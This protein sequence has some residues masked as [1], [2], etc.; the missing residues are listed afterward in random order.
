MAPPRVGSPTSPAVNNACVPEAPEAPVTTK[1]APLSSDLASSRSSVESWSGANTSRAGLLHSAPPASSGPM[2]GPTSNATRF[3]IERTLARQER[4]EALV[5]D[6]TPALETEARVHR[7]ISSSSLP[8]NLTDDV[9]KAL[10]QLPPD[11]VEAAVRESVQRAFPKASAEKLETLQRQTMAV[12][13]DTKYQLAQDLKTFISDKID[14]GARN[15]LATAKD[16]AQLEALLRHVEQLPLVERRETF[17]ALGLAPEVK[18]P[19]AAQLAKA[20]TERAAVMMRSAKDLR[21]TS[22]ADHTLFRIANYPGVEADFAKA[23]KIEPDSFAGHALHQTVADAASEKGLRAKA[24]FALGVA[25]AAAFGAVAAVVGAG[26]LGSAAIAAPATLLNTA[27]KVSEADKAVVDATA[28]ESA[29]VM[30]RGT[31]KAAQ[32]HRS[33][34]II[35]GAAEAVAP[36]GVHGIGQALH[37]PHGAVAGAISEG[38]AALGIGAGESTLAHHPEGDPSL[39][40]ATRR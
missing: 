4:Q 30:A 23:R 5:N 39:R 27:R 38:A 7:G 35:A 20:L 10:S 40:D 22:G 26:A 36:V 34:T 12:L 29:G 16:P 21:D 8:M 11:Q 2:A 13:G 28:G 24:D 37:L 32:D 17:S 18:N 15:F 14:T 3:E 33:L 6:L 31:V 19:S 25:S 9:K 1:S